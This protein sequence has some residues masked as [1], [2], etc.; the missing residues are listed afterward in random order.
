MKVFGWDRWWHYL[1]GTIAV[2]VFRYIAGYLDDKWGILS[3]EQD[4]LTR[5]NLEWNK[6]VKK[7]DEINDKLNNLMVYKRL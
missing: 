2:V 5:K 3:N 7:I 6:L 1:L 4:Q